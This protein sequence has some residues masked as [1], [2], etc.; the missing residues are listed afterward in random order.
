MDITP[1]QRDELERTSRKAKKP[2]MR[3]KALVLL[4]IA[5]GLRVTQTAKVF[6]V[7]RQTIHEWMNRYEEEGIA[8]LY[9]RL[10]RGRKATVN[11][12]ELENYV[13][14]SPR[15]FGISRT[16]WTLAAL[17]KSVPS[18]KGFTPYGVQKALRRIGVHYKR[19]QAWVHS[20]DPEYEQ[21]KRLS[22]KR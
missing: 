10:G 15:N 12:E 1:V 4:N 21:K 20:P 19:G 17:A 13:R 11:Y 9:V 16:R 18:V 5:D 6:R 8:G 22:K 2:Y 14:Q 3:I 7:S